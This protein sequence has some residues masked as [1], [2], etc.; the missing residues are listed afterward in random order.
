MKLN[1]YRYFIPYNLRHSIGQT[2]IDT[3][4]DIRNFNVGDINSYILWYPFLPDLTKHILDNTTTTTFNTNVES[5][6]KSFSHEPFNQ[7]FRT[8]LKNPQEC[9]I[10]ENNLY[11]KDWYFIHYGT[12]FNNTVEIIKEFYEDFNKYVN[13]YNDI[14]NNGY[15]HIGEYPHGII[16]QSGNL[17]LMG[18]RHRLTFCKLLDIPTIKIKVILQ[19]EESTNRSI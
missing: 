10:N 18:G 3:S 16:D 17:Q 4:N 19:H 6:I 9:L 11:F 1:N 12:E 13:I 2:L 14:K 15:K 5:L 8:W 7:T